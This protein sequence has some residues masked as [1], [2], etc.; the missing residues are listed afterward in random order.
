MVAVVSRGSLHDKVEIDQEMA[1][2][3]AVKQRSAFVLG[4]MFTNIN[5]NIYISARFAG[6]ECITASGLCRRAISVRGDFLAYAPAALVAPVT[7]CGLLYF[8]ARR[9]LKYNG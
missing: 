7:V 3:Q 4:K 9:D 2:E 5:T 1:T 8:V 6:P